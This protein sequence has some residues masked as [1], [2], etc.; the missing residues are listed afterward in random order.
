MNGNTPMH[1]AM[2]LENKEEII[3]LKQGFGDLIDLDV[4]NNK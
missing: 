2:V 1:I 4:K 3:A